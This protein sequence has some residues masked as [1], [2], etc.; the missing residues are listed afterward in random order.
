MNGEYIAFKYRLCSVNFP[1]ANNVQGAKMWRFY[2]MISPYV[3]V[4]L[5]KH[6]MSV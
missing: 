1:V 3:I 4:N 5:D 6:L 2:T